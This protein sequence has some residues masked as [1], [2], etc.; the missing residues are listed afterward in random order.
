[1]KRISELDNL[2]DADIQDTD[3]VEVARPITKNFKFTWSSLKTAL[4][5]LFDTLYAALTHA[6]RHQSGGADEINVAGLSG[7][8]VDNQPPKTHAASHQNAG[9]DE[10]SVAGLSGELADNQPP[11]SHN[12]TAHS[13]TYITDTV[14]HGN[15][16]H[17][18]IFSQVGATSGEITALTEKTTPANDDVFIIEDSEETNAPKKLKLSS[19]PAP[20]Y[21]EKTMVDLTYGETLAVNNAVYLKATDGKVYKTDADYSDERTQNFVGFAKEAGDAEDV[22]K[23]QTGGKVEEFSGLTAGSYYYVSATAG[24]ITLSKPTAP[25]IVGLALSATEL[26]IIRKWQSEASIS[27]RAANAPTERNT[28]ETS[29]TKLKEIEILYDGRYRTKFGL[30][31]NGANATYGKIYKNG[32][33]LGTERYVDIS[34]YT[35]FEEDFDFVKGDLVQV[36]ARVTNV[37]H[38]AYVA[39]Y[40]LL[41]YYVPPTKVITD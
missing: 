37:A 18:P 30:R 23:V 31:S 13:E 14:E 17:N 9:S 19:I 26:L 11:K 38:I 32:V 7:E 16:K 6:A 41:S 21:V 29:Y 34:T 36:Y 40:E 39:Y 8:L 33:A 10:I 2:T 25:A 3:L 12:N 20:E 24:E 4:T 15:E 5:T 27:T 35:Y 22:K 1:M 28:Q